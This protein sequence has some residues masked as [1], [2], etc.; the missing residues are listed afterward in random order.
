M[1]LAPETTSR[2]FDCFAM[3]KISQHEATAIAYRNAGQILEAL[4][5]NAG[6]Y[7]FRMHGSAHRIYFARIDE[8]TSGMHVLVEKLAAYDSNTIELTAQR[9]V[10]SWK[11][12]MMWG[13]AERF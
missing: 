1:M 6:D 3:N 9:I 2:P 8:E 10:R 7:G 11:D 4:Y 13:S 12:N 5:R